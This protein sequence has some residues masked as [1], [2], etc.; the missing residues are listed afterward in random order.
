MP[1]KLSA[2]AIL[3]ANEQDTDT[4]WLVLLEISFSDT[5]EKMR[6]VRNTEDIQWDG[7]LWTH[8]PFGCSDSKN[9]NKGTLP[10][11]SIE[12]DNTTRDLEYYLNEYGGGT[13]ASVRLMVVRSDDLEAAEPD[14]EEIYTVKSTSVTAA[15]VTFTLGNEYSQKARRPFGRYMKNSCPFKYKGLRC[16]CTSS[17]AGCNHTLSDC[18]ERGNS[19]RFGGFPGIPQGG[20]YV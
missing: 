12:V 17:L 10:V 1:L 4:A 19:T 2:A 20:T 7:Q 5:E 15:K 11:L 3:A 8:F 18:R 13:G 6:L 9:D 14:F 16:G